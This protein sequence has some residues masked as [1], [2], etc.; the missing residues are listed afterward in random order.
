M[1]TYGDFFLPVV[2]FWDCKP[3]REGVTGRK[4]PGL[5]QIVFEEARVAKVL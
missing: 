2:N 5:I 3:E 1:N 4:R